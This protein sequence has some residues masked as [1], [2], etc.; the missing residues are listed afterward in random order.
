L[1]GSVVRAPSAEPAA[2]AAMR[3][4]WNRLLDLF[5]S[6]DARSGTILSGRNSL[7]HDEAMMMSGPR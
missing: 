7:P 2:D 3:G 6:N 4:A 1:K 5:V